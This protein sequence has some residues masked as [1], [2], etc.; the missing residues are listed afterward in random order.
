MRVYLGDA[1]GRGGKDLE[2]AVK[3]YLGTWLDEKG[4]QSSPKNVGEGMRVYLGAPTAQSAERNDLHRV[5]EQ[6]VRPLRILFSYH[7][8][9]DEDLDRCMNEALKGIPCDVFAD[10]GAFSA[11][12][13]GH[14]ITVQEYADWLAKWGHYFTC[15]AALDVIGDAVGSFK[16]TE[17]LRKLVDPKLN[18]LPV[19]HSNDEGGFK[20]LQAYFDAGYDYI[21][22]SPTGAIYGN[23]KLMHAWLTK[24]FQMRPAHVK[25]HG[26]G[27][28]GWKVLK[29]FPWYSVDSSSWTS[30]FRYATLGLFD[31][32]RGEWVKIAMRSPKELLAAAG[33]F[34]AYGLRPSEVRADSYDR[35]KL[36]GACVIS[37]QRAEAWLERWHQ[38]PQRMY[39]GTRTGEKTPNSPD[40]I[41][42]A[43]KGLTP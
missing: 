6:G 14:P 27:V 21:G 41:G 1:A 11:W 38:M 36:C 17:E 39:L 19:F 30:G 24:C 13:T 23:P 7:Y 37:W 16:Q 10:S 29:A 34:K 8:Y 12:T 25:Y 26:F 40:T 18:I 32:K 3:V 33:V 42:R 5:A 20:W 22:I 43:L 31:D 28:T 2:A 4:A 15:A 35:D 9:K